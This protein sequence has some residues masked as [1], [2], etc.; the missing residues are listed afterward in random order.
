MDE[1]FTGQLF[2]ILAII[3]GVIAILN[4]LKKG[5]DREKDNAVKIAEMSKDLLAQATGRQT[6]EVQ[7]QKDFRAH[8]IANNNL[9]EKMMSEIS[10]VNNAL[11]ILTKAQSDMV[12]TQTTMMMEQ[13]TMAG[14]VK[15]ILQ[16]INNE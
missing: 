9:K 12:K 1:L 11:N 14:D 10:H 13:A 16:K 8:E 7:M 5:T 2:I 6:L 4:Y 15:T 3:G